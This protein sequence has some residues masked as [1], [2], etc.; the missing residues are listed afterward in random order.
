MQQRG[1]GGRPSRNRRRTQE[2][3]FWKRLNR[4]L[5][6]LIVLGV[7]A[8]VL[9]ATLP[10]WRRVQAW[11]A[12]LEKVKAEEREE[13]LTLR[14]HQ[15]TLRLIDTDPEYVETLARDRLGLMKEG[16]TIIRLP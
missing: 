15:R 8:L 13:E 9:V 14:Q 16:E 3:E 5:A 6:A 10:E 12:R 2:A 4:T 11:E 7:L 1:F